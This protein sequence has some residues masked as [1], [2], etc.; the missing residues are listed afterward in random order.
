MYRPVG[1]GRYR[2]YES[3]RTDTKSETKQKCT[4]FVKLPERSVPTD[5][6]GTETELITLVSNPSLYLN[7]YFLFRSFSSSSMLRSN[8]PGLVSSPTQS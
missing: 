7:F 3:V 1:T 5:T 2:W 6:A 4:N 8:V